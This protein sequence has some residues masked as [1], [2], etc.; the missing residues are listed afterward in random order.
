MTVKEL[1][2]ALQKFDPN[3]E[4][5]RRNL[6]FGSEERY[7]SDEAVSVERVLGPGDNGHYLNVDNCVTI[8]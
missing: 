8:Y 2:A 6:D 5:R 3:A 1:I 4:V 7:E